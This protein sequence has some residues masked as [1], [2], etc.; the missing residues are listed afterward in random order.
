MLIS[1]QNLQRF[2]NSDGVI[3]KALKDV[4]FDISKGEFVAIMGSSGSGKSTLMHILGFLDRQTDGIYN[5][6]NIDTKNLDDNELAKLRNEEIGF[7][8]QSFNLLKKTTVFDNIMLPLIYS[9]KFKNLK[10]KRTQVLNIIEEVGLSHRVYHLSNQLS[11][12]EK[13]RV[14]IARALINKPK[15]IF[16]DEPTGN[17]DSKTGIQIMEILEEL[18]NKGNTVILVTHETTTANYAKRIITLKDGLLLKD[19]TV[20]IRSKNVKNL[21]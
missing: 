13:Q 2:F 14:A 9:K 1:I 17:L 7:V 12:G 10:G 11:G 18:N 5:F 4:S 21:K 15:V 20:D 3:T 6:N 19:H 8:F 16:A